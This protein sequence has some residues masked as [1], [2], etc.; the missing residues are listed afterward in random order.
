[1]GPRQLARRGLL[2]ATAEF[3]LG[4]LTAQGADHMVVAGALA[5]PRGASIPVLGHIAGA[6]S[7]VYVRL[8]KFPPLVLLRT[9]R[10]S[11]PNVYVTYL[12]VCPMGMIF[13]WWR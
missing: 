1:M 11:K 4:E 13:F 10:K 6:R 2:A 8:P 12:S 9:C 5:F 7:Q 3:V